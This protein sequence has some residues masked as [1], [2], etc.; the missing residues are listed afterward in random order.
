M[1]KKGC[2]SAQHQRRIR[3]LCLLG[4]VSCLTS[5]AALAPYRAR[6][7]QALGSMEK[8]NTS[9]SR[10]YLH[11]KLQSKATQYSHLSPQTSFRKIQLAASLNRQFRWAR[12]PRCIAPTNTLQL[13][14]ATCAM[15][16][17]RLCPE[18]NT[19]F[20]LDACTTSMIF[21]T[22]DGSDNCGN[23]LALRTPRR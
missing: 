20:F 11:Y 12:T 6:S 4:N 5:A 8:T 7:A 15:R 19:Y 17:P 2:L 23:M 21:S 22:T 9:Y 3:I 13:A 10:A 16:V 1:I 14:L 18:A